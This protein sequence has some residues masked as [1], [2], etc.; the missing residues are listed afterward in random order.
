M[1]DLA[2]EKQTTRIGKLTMNE[3]WMGERAYDTIIATIFMYKI[4]KGMYI[5]DI[6][7]LRRVAL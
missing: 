1:T 4:G 5:F 2:S 3:L 7:N 6:T